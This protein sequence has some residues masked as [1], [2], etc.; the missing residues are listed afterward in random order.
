M[1]T[2]EE[3]EKARK[4]LMDADCDKDAKM[5]IHPEGLIVSDSNGWRVIRMPPQASRKAAG[6]FK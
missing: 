6:A 3:F 5:W 4:A 2:E 1:I